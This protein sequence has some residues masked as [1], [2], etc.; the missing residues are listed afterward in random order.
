MFYTR[1]HL[2]RQDLPLETRAEMNATLMEAVA[3]GQPLT[4]AEAK[5]LGTS[6]EASY[7]FEQGA[8][9][10]LEKIYVQ[11]DIYKFWNI[12]MLYAQDLDGTGVINSPRG[13][14]PMLQKQ[15]DVAYLQ[16]EFDAW[17]Q[18]IQKTNHKHTIMQFLSKQ[19]RQEWKESMAWSKQMGEGHFR[20]L[21][22]ERAVILQSKFVF[23]KVEE[24]YQEYDVRKDTMV[25]CGQETIVDGF[26]Y[27]HILMRHFSPYNKFGRPGLT[28]H[29]DPAI[30]VANLPRSIFKFLRIYDA[31]FGGASFARENIYFQLNG[32]NYVIWFKQFERNIKGGGTSAYLRVQ[33]FYPA[34]LA[35]DSSAMAVLKKVQVEEH[36]FFYI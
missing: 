18:Q 3:N 7:T 23:I 32:R 9:V 12:Y 15:I 35:N 8:I 6:L 13:P 19:A 20:R 31:Y 16:R 25:F 1:D 29:H 28:F 10:L 24:Y 33:T 2:D 36:L 5:Y 17:K 30:E 11:L 14:V 22:V 26:A 21:Y 4:F 27:T 34:E